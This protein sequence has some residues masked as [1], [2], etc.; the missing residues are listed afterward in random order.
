[1][2]IE[3]AFTRK[4]P[5][6]DEEKKTTLNLNINKA[7]ISV[8]TDMFFLSTF[9]NLHSLHL[10]NC[11]LESILPLPHL[12]HLVLLDLSFNKISVSCKKLRYSKSRI[13]RKPEVF[14]SLIC[15][16]L[17]SN[18]LLEIPDL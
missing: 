7:N 14:P 2:T 11:K 1:M 13:G 12:Q 15:L 3:Q 18:K 17:Y 9:R 10:T 16:N 5:S 4:Y 8:P 6:L